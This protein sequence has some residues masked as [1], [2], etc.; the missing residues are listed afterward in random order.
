MR[1]GLVA[2]SLLVTA[3]GCEDASSPGPLPSRVSVTGVVRDTLGLPIIGTIVA[4]THVQTA[5]EEE[6]Q[7]DDAGR[8]RAEA[9]LSLLDADTIFVSIFSPYCGGGYGPPIPVDIR[10]RTSADTVFQLDITLPIQAPRPSPTACAP[11]IATPTSFSP[12]TRFWNSIALNTWWARAERCSVD[13][14]SITQVVA[15]SA[16]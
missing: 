16:M 15:P 1:Y 7:T 2:L 5:P 13:A 12:T 3:T 11:T 9:D 6:L 8:Y 14:G 10:H 4:Y